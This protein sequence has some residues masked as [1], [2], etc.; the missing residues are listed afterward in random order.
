MK[1]HLDQQTDPRKDERAFAEAM[2]DVRPDRRTEQPA[3]DRAPFSDF[4][5]KLRRA[6][7]QPNTK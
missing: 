1:Q 2:A 7:Q 6:L 4:A 5:E 3:A